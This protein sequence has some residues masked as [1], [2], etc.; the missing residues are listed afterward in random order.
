MTRRSTSGG[1]LFRGSQFLNTWCKVQT[2]LATSSAEAELYALCKT[3]SEALGAQ[4]LMADLGQV[5]DVHV[6]IDSSAA[7]S[8]VSK[9]GLGKAK[10]M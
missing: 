5:T 10:H 8:L 7:L 3:S 9:V 2:S 6:H 1:A 4:S